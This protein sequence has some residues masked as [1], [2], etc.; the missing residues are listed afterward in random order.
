MGLIWASSMIMLDSARG[1]ARMLWL[2]LASKPGSGHVLPLGDGFL[3][4][5]LDGLHAGLA[6]GIA[7]WRRL[8]AW[9]QRPGRSV[10]SETP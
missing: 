5:D 9:Q 10:P 3:A 2:A 4:P 1:G 7:R 8:Q 6:S